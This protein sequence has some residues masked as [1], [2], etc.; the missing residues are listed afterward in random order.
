MEWEVSM[1]GVAVS[2]DVQCP[3]PA[4][5]TLMYADESCDGAGREWATVIYR[6]SECSSH[7]EWPDSNGTRQLPGLRQRACRLIRQHDTRCRQTHSPR[8][9]APMDT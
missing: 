8:M 5:A 3:L 1:S 9:Q 4:T 6:M 7:L 2:S